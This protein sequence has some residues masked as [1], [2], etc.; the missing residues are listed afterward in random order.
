[1]M[2]SRDDVTFPG[3][4]CLQTYY[5]SREW[6]GG[7]GDRATCGHARTW[8]DRFGQCQPASHHSVFSGLFHLSTNSLHKTCRWVSTLLYDLGWWLLRL[9]DLFYADVPLRSYSFI[10]QKGTKSSFQ[11]IFHRIFV[12]CTH[13]E[14]FCKVSM[15]TTFLLFTWPYFGLYFLPAVLLYS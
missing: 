14:M 8:Q 15:V 13:S 6:S 2:T 4:V 10:C 1:M 5:T 9:N 7:R 12:Y 11:S 3:V